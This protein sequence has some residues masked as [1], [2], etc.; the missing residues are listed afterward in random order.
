MLDTVAEFSLSAC[1]DTFGSAGR[2]EMSILSNAN[3]LRVPVMLSAMYGV[4]RCCSCGLT[5]NCCTKAGYAV[6]RRTETNASKPTAITGRLH[7]RTR[8]FTRNSTAQI[9]ATIARKFSAGSCAWTSVYDAPSTTPR[10]D[11]SRSNL[12]R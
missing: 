3:A 8:M 1:V 4:S 9:T 7:S 6:P 12:P 10:G 2:W 11:V 5:L